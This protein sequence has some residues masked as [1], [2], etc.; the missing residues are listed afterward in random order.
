MKIVSIF[1]STKRRVLREGQFA[2]GSVTFVSTFLKIP[3]RLNLK[4]TSARQIKK[5]RTKVSVINEDF[6]D[7]LA[8]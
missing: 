1:Q 7:I 6:H 4:H 8:C 5:A 3:V 2:V